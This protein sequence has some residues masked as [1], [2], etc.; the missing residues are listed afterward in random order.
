MLQ[1]L[2]C[3]LM[4]LRVRIPPPVPSMDKKMI[5]KILLIMIITLSVLSVGMAKPKSVLIGGTVTAF[6]NV[7]IET[8]PGYV[9]KKGMA[10]A[11]F[12][13]AAGFKWNEDYPSSFKIR[14][15]TNSSVAIPLEKEI[16]LTKGKLCV[17]YLGKEP[18]RTMVDGVINFSICN[19]KEC[20]IFRNEK[21]TLVL[22]VSE[23][24]D[25]N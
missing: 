12:K 10:K 6:F 17:P 18:G 16:D 11:I 22:I 4:G 23:N 13:P 1:S 24:D 14:K 9:G 20:L 21:I 15:A 7:Q 3:C 8:V 5:K 19:K 2:I 25:N